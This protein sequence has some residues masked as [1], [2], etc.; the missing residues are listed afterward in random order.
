[1]LQSRHRSPLLTGA[2][3]ASLAETLQHMSSALLGIGEHAVEEAGL[4]KRGLHLDLLLQDSAA[5]FIDGRGEADKER[6]IKTWRPG[7]C[8]VLGEEVTPA[9]HPFGTRTGRLISAWCRRIVHPED[10]DEGLA[11]SHGS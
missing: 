7:A 4:K 9:F 11:T 10:Q 2:V 1:M 5:G 8:L 3:A 6:H